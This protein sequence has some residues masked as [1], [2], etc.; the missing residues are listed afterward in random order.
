ML[1]FCVHGVSSNKVVAA[2]GSWSAHH[3]KL[4]MQQLDIRSKI[5]SPHEQST[6]TEGSLS[7]KLLS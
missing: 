2:A 3:V 7:T 6:R 4:E 1:P 5:R